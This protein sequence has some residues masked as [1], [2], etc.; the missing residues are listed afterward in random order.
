MKPALALLAIVALPASAVAQTSQNFSPEEQA[1]VLAEMKRLKA[2]R[3]LTTDKA[4]I[5]YDQCLARAA[6]EVSRTDVPDEAVFGRARVLC[7]PTRM[8]LLSN[9]PPER[10]LAFK[11]LDD[12]KAASF[13]AMTKQI[14]KRR[15]AMDSQQGSTP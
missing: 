15:L 11:A 9:S 6:V 13:P 2:V 12:Q 3:G 14:R 4:L 1:V 5:V 10:F 7:G 8:D